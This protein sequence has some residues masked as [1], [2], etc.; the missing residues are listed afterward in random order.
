[1]KYLRF[2]A[3]FVFF[4]IVIPI[5]IVATPIFL[6]WEMI[7]NARRGILFDFS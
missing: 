2:K 1:M 3:G 4:F 5:M 6:V 7:N